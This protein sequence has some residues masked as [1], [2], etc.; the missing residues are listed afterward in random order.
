VEGA[1]AGCDGLRTFWG[2]FLLDFPRCSPVRSETLSLS[3]AW[4][5]VTRGTVTGEAIGQLAYGLSP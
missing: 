4:V 2:R 1:I 5:W 3:A